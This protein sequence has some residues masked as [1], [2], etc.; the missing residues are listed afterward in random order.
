MSV[1]SSE[2]CLFL[3]DERGGLIVSGSFGGNKQIPEK[4][5][6]SKLF[7]HIHVYSKDKDNNELPQFSFISGGKPWFL[8]KCKREEHPVEEST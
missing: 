7:K 2:N 8:H 3:I 6:S 5:T 1:T 4:T